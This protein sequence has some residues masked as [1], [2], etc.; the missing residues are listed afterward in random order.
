MLLTE[1]RVKYIHYQIQENKKIDQAKS[2]L[3]RR[4]KVTCNK[5]TIAK[6]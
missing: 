5:D 4:I 6:W 3:K 1:V 2:K